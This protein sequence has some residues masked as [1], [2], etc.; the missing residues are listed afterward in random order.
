MSCENWIGLIANGACVC[1]LHEFNRYKL[2]VVRM[3][4]EQLIT[5][6]LSAD[7]YLR[8]ILYLLTFRFYQLETHQLNCRNCVAD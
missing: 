3:R 1:N 8:L 6:A 7:R 2:T 4:P 5:F